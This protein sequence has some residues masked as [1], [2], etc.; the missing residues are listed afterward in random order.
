VIWDIDYYWFF[1]VID[2]FMYTK[3]Y[4]KKEII[5]SLVLIFTIALSFALPKTQLIQYDIQIFAILFIILFLVRKI[6]LTNSSKSRLLE[7]VIFT[8]TILIIVNTT[9]G[10]ESS[11]FFLIYFLLFSL[12]LILEPIISITST[13]TLIILFLM[14]LPENQNLKNL[15]PIFSL[16]FLTPFALFMGQEYIENQKSKVKDQKLEEDTFLFLSL[17][18]KNQ[19]KNIK[20]T[21]DN[22]L[23]DHDLDKIK[24]SIRRMEQL[25]EKFENSK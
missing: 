24:Q 15:L 7:S 2:Y 17:M 13:I 8:L 10:V 23:G 1:D 9:G 20:Y 19:L 4:M 25:I 6:L 21:V 5:H 14:S 12:S 11:F 16:A 3:L 18:I 22:F